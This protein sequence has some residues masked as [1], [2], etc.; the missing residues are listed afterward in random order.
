MCGLDRARVEVPDDT[1][2]AQ[3]V[4]A[5]L[6]E[7]GISRDGLPPLRFAVNETFVTADHAPREGDRV[8]VL[9]PFAG[10]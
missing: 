4:D 2:V 6:S 7:R 9:T 3:I 10:G 1:N 5:F 8:A